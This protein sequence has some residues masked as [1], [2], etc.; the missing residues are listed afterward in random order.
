M[1]FLPLISRCHACCSNHKDPLFVSFHQY[2]VADVSLTGCLAATNKF[3]MY[4]DDHSGD[5]G[6]PELEKLA[7]EFLAE[8][9]DT[10]LQN[11]PQVPHPYVT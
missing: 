6:L 9:E 2:C 7:K 4:D 10:A 5:L 1:G 8:A 11:S 3:K